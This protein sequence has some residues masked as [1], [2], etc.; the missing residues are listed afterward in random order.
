MSNR[1]RQPI[2][3]PPVDEAPAAPLHPSHWHKG[4]LLNVIKYNDGTCRIVLLGEELDFQ[5][6]NFLELDSMHAAQTFVSNW[7][8]R[9]AGR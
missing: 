7:Y 6:P 8:A 2:I 3:E 4:Q 5:K 1:K 9:E